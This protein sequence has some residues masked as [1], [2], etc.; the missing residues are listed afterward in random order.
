LAGEAI[1]AVRL[2]ALCATLLLVA[3]LFCA[4]QARGALYIGTSSIT[5]ANLDGSL[6]EAGFIP[7]QNGSVW[8]IAADSSHLYWADSYDNTIG[9]APV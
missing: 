8:A 5:R 1:D 7:P 2:A 9:A 6:L 4:S 3:F